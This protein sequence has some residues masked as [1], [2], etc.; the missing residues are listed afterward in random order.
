[1]CRTTPFPNPVT[2]RTAG[3]CDR[4]EAPPATPAFILLFL[5]SPGSLP[6]TWKSADESGSNRCGE[7]SCHLVIWR[8]RKRRVWGVLTFRYTAPARAGNGG[9]GHGCCPVPIRPTQWLTRP[10]GAV[11]SPPAGRRSSLCQQHRDPGIEWTCI[12]S[13]CPSASRPSKVGPGCRPEPQPA[14]SRT[15]CLPCPA[16]WAGCS[17]FGRNTTKAFRWH[18]TAR[19]TAMAFLP[20]FHS[21]TCRI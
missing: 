16:Y 17:A 13:L 9:R 12:S 4:P 2:A 20:G 8:G 3:R 7:T 1:M 15:R 10:N 14:Y 11:L 6:E 21:C 18:S 19:Q 5:S